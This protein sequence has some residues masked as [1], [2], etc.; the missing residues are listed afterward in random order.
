M[1]HYNNIKL[2]IESSNFSIFCTNNCDISTWFWFV[3]F[4]FRCMHFLNVDLYA[5]FI[6]LQGS[7]HWHRDIRRFNCVTWVYSDKIGW[8]L[9]MTKTTKC[10]KYLQ[11]LGLGIHLYLQDIWLIISLKV[12]FIER[13]RGASMHMDFKVTTIDEHHLYSLWLMG[14]KSWSWLIKS[15]VLL[16]NRQKTI[17]Y[18]CNN[19]NFVPET[20]GKRCPMKINQ[21]IW[22]IWVR[23]PILELV[24]R[25]TK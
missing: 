6:I 5:V 18:T 4:C 13:I 9:V 20:P 3:L 16:S 7:P 2:A 14:H 25:R 11:L 17:F 21:N 22:G 19:V 8:Y 23:L 15:N 10:L 1:P 24:S 12:I